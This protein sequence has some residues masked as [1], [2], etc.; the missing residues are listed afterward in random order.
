MTILESLK[1]LGLEA[2]DGIT[3]GVSEQEIAHVEQLLQ[4]RLPNEY[5][6][7]LRKFG[8]SRF[9]EDV[10]FSPMEP[11]S[12]AV[13]GDECFDLF[14]GITKNPHANIVNINQRLKKKLSVGSIAIGHDSGLNLIL[15]RPETNEV[16]FLERDTGRT[17]L[18]ANSF[19]EFLR[20]FHVR[21]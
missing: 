2:A 20:R 3:H 14:Y 15:L 6:E 12:W 10:V 18:I 7:F 4:M 5:R 16:R 8:A 19:N 1:S 21:K 13:D 17:Y 11:S 9:T